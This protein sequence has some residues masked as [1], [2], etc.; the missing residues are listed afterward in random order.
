MTVGREVGE[1]AFAEAGLTDRGLAWAR[2]E[3]G[4]HLRWA[5]LCLGWSGKGESNRERSGGWVWSEG[6]CPSHS[7][8][9]AMGAIKRGVL[10]K[11]RT[12][13]KGCFETVVMRERVPAPL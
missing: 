6:C 12:L 13:L 8:P 7:P 5:G 2:E 10:S 11:K 4:R 1:L 9:W 3:R